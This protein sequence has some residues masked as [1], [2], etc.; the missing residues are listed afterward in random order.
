MQYTVLLQ[1]QIDPMG[2]TEKLWSFAKFGMMITWNKEVSR[3]K[4]SC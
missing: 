2:L 4:F 1:K 3:E